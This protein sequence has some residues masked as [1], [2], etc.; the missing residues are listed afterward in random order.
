ME[1]AKLKFNRIL[2]S[3]IDGLVMF[4]LMVAICIFPAIN[5]IRDINEQVLVV[6][7]LLWLLFSF[8]ASFAVCIL[9]LFL[10][11]LIFRGA[12]FGMRINRLVFVKSNDTSLRYYNLLFRHFVNILCIVFS[13]GFSVIFDAIS[14]ICTEKGRNFYDILTSMKVVNINDAI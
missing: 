12:T 2:A 6:S 8:F 7:D 13:L 9:Y 11:S 14:M 1:V 4:I 3:L 5:V 10:S